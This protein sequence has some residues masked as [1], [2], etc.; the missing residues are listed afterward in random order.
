M[1]GLAAAFAVAG[2]DPVDWADQRL[3]ELGQSGTPE[4]SAEQSRFGF[5]ATSQRPDQWRVAWEDA[6]E[7]P[8]L[9]AGR[10]VVRV[11]LRAR[12]GRRPHGA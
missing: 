3:D 1:V 8:L 7:D 6:R 9:R 11:H 2:E 5:D 4:L 12:A 10:G